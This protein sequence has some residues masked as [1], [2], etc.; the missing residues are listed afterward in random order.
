[1]VDQ[2]QEPAFTV[3][4]R[5]GR[6]GESAEPAGETSPRPSAPHPSPEG[7]TSQR[8]PVDFAGFV[9][10]LAASALMHLGEPGPDG[11]PGTTDLPRA[12]EMIDLLALLE[13]KTRGNLTPDESHV[14]TNLLYTLRIRY[15]EK[16]R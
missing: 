5:R 7:E 11:H 15:V 1:M 10:S 8:E 14:L 2:P 12:Q 13:D 3:T 9:F 16:A 4:D 6:T